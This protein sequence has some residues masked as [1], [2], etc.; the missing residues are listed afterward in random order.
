[1]PLKVLEVQPRSP[2]AKAGLCA[3]DT[4]LSINTMPINDFFDLEYY[5]ND[6]KLD[7]ELLDA[8]GN[9]KTAMVLRQ[10]N[11]ALGVEPE[12]HQVAS[13]SNSC[14]FCFID[15]LP[16]GLRPTLYLK[17]DDYLFS[18]V[19]G[20]YIT[21]NNL[22]DHQ[23]QRIVDQRISPLY[24]SVHSTDPRLRAKLMRNRSGLDILQALRN[25]SEEGISFHLQ[26]VCVPEYN[27][28]PEL[29]KTLADL[30]D[31]SVEALSIGVVPVGLTGHRKGL[32]DL[33]PFTLELAAETIT[34]VD[35][36]RSEHPVVQAADELFMLTG[37]PV[38]GAD[39]YADYP[40][41]EN[42][43]G[44]LRL[45]ADNFQRRRKALARELDKTRMDH[46]ILTS[47]LAKPLLEKMAQDLN[48]RLER[49]SL[50]VQALENRFFGGYVTVSGLLSGSDVLEQHTAGI[51]EGLII[52]SSIF[53]PDGLTLDDLSQVELR[54]S[55]GRPLLV[56]DQYFEDWEW[57]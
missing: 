32:T 38:P 31:G 42:G 36:F 44:M 26:I 47:R 21:L 19:F 20:N 53:N 9:S 22:G 13:C 43:I 10:F 27:C 46:V 25:L 11:K 15:Q 50:R 48:L 40:Q 37:R 14:V 24:V 3:G 52:P 30:L 1:M 8:R 41:L 33:K 12:P 55:L 56:V 7:F 49:S 51:N 45:S 17:D 29:R 6:Y 35:E 57:I 23:L 2:A 16:P 28:G 34:I 39:Y 18:Y 5:A 4:I 54:E